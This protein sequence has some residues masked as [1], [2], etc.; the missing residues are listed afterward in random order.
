M[1]EEPAD[2]LAEVLRVGQF[3][4]ARIKDPPALEQCGGSDTR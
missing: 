3:G 1:V 4:I 2:A